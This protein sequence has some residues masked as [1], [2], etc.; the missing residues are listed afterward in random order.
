[1]K[2]GQ[3][4]YK[5]MMETAGFVFPVKKIVPGSVPE[6]RSQPSPRDMDKDPIAVAVSY[7]FNSSFVH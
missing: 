1:M 2:N 7:S 6:A 4:R 5:T 3:Q